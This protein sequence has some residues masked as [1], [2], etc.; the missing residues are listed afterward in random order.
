MAEM[1]KTR[2]PCFLLPVSLQFHL[3]QQNGFCIFP[4]KETW[5]LILHQEPERGYKVK[6][7]LH[8]RTPELH[9]ALLGRPGSWSCYVHNYH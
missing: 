2:K 3:D 5:V 9:S 1:M 7:S 6:D 4:E 8:N